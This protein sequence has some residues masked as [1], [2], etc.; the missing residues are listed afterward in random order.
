[1]KKKTYIIVGILTFIILLIIGGYLF[2][3]SSLS[4][5]G[6][7][8]GGRGPDYPYFITTE[9]TTVK[10]IIVPKGTI[11]TYEEQFFKEGKQ[12]KIMNENK[13]TDIQLPEGETIIWGG[14]PVNMI[15]KFFN[16]EM[17]GFTVY[18]DFSQLTDDKKTK[19]SKL[20]ES[21]DNQLSVDVKNI[22]DWSFND[23]N[24]TD[25]QSCGVNKQRYF[26]EDKSQQQFL[27]NLY[28]ELTKN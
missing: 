16:T 20:W 19:F 17:R 27:D 13:L 8:T 3:L 21:E 18:A 2:L 9:P 28:N 25:V 14:V 5:M 12:D 4:G 1:M 11:L 10:K 26:Q 7:P 24:I 6:N 22:D 23:T 15:V